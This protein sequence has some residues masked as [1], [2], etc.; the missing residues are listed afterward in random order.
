MIPGL[1]AITSETELP[2]GGMFPNK[3][4]RSAGRQTAIAKTRAAY[5][6]SLSSSRNCFIA[7]DS[8]LFFL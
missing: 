2:Y 4:W 7:G 6:V 3:K 8:T 1:M 5:D